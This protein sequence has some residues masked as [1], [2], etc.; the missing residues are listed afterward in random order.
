MPDGRR[1]SLEHVW[2]KNASRCGCLRLGGVRARQRLGRRAA[3]GCAGLDTGTNSPDLCSPAGKSEAPAGP[4]STSSRRVPVSL[5]LL[6]LHPARA[7]RAAQLLQPRLAQRELNSGWSGRQACS[8]LLQHPAHPGLTAR[9]LARSGGLSCAARRAR[10]VPCC[11][12]MTRAPLA[13]GARASWSSGSP[14]AARE[15]PSQPLQLP[16]CASY[17][18]P[19]SPER[20]QPAATQD[21]GL[22]GR[23]PILLQ[24]QCMHGRPPGASLR[25]ALPRLTRHLAVVAAQGS[26][27]LSCLAEHWCCSSPHC[28][29]AG[30]PG[31][32][33][34][35]CAARRWCSPGSGLGPALP[36]CPAQPAQRPRRAT[37]APTATATWTTAP[38]TPAPS[39][40]WARPARP[41]SGPCLGLSDRA[42]S[43]TEA[44]SQK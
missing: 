5:P 26:M 8:G 15:L 23:P 42:L 19:S 37:A 25:P 43:C 39:S 44:Y 6:V 21:R 34:S 17:H 9:V 4:A 29:D 38:R 24:G 32:T 10:A 2:L 13:A 18:L 27:A 12:T 11:S 41:R 28:P 30:R 3:A 16:G 31:S 14:A 33:A 36:A 40:A 22:A 20:V 1:G 35:S 7:C